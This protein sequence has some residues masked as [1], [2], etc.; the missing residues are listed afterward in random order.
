MIWK[1]F[2]NGAEQEKENVPLTEEDLGQIAEG[3][4]VGKADQSPKKAVKKICLAGGEGVANVWE[5]RGSGLMR[6]CYD[7]SKRVQGTS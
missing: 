2:E 4:D 6:K 7:L 5:R 1:R 3:T